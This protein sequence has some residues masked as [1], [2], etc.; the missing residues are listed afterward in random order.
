MCRTGV[1]YLFE[2]LKTNRPKAICSNY[3]V[4]GE[5][6]LTLNFN[7]T[8]DL[9]MLSGISAHIYRHYDQVYA[10]YTTIQVKTK[11]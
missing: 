3:T 11:F 7:I 9:D 1:P 4:Y 5:S 10:N 8:N 6:G 2:R